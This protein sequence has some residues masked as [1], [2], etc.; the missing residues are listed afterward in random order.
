MIYC[1]I[2]PWT[3][4]TQPSNG[5]VGKMGRGGRERG[6]ES[7]PGSLDIGGLILGLGTTIGM[8]SLVV[9]V[10]VEAIHSS[11]SG[12]SAHREWNARRPGFCSSAPRGT[13]VILGL[14]RAF[15]LV[16]MRDCEANTSSSLQTP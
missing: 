9:N 15:S 10:G 11:S 4:A 16:L 2:R 7:I 12:A 8:E 3:M 13:P 6:I 14:A 5:D 1:G